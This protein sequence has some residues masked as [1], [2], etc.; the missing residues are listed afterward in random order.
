MYA[1][2]IFIS[3]AIQTTREINEENKGTAAEPKYQDCIMLQ[4]LYAEYT[5]KNNCFF[6]NLIA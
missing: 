6:T 1:A 4:S 2:Y 5:T 3:K